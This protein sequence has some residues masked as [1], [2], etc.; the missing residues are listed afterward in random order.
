MKNIKLLFIAVVAVLIIQAC[1][2]SDGNFTGSEYMPD[3]KHA[4]T[5][6]ANVLN[7]Y[8]HNT[9]NDESTITLEDLALV[10]KILR[11]KQIILG[12]F[13]NMRR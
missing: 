2:P 9:W 7:Y 13:L 10:V 8:Y 12:I 5:L 6:E 11:S 1:S 4:I 3:M